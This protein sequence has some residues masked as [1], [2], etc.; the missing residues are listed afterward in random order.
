MKGLYSIEED[1]IVSYG[2]AYENMSEE[3]N[4][5]D[6][7]K[8]FSFERYS[9]SSITSGIFNPEG[10]VLNPEFIETI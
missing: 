2:T 1:K 6:I 7:P 8:D 3:D 5:Y 10:F 9:Y 4:V